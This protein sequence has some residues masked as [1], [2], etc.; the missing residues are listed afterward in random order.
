MTSCGSELLKHRVMLGRAMLLLTQR[1]PPRSFA[2]SLTMGASCGQNPLPNFEFTMLLLGQSQ[3]FKVWPT[4]QRS[5]LMVQEKRLPSLTQ[6][7][8]RTTPI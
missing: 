2:T 3:V 4:T 6:A 8:T 5:P 1:R 7:L